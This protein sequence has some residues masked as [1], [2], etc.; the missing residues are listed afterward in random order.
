MS[1]STLGQCWQPMLVQWK[2]SVG[3]TLVLCC[4]A[5]WSYTFRSKMLQIKDTISDAR[6]VVELL[7]YLLWVKTPN[8]KQ[9]CWQRL[10]RHW[11]R[12]IQSWRHIFRIPE[13]VVWWPQSMQR[14][15][16]TLRDIYLSGK[17]HE[18][19]KPINKVYVSLKGSVYDI[20]FW[21]YPYTPMCVALYTQYFPRVLWKKSQAFLLGWDSNPRPLQLLICICLVWLWTIMVIATYLVRSRAACN[22]VMNTYITS[23]PQY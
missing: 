6:V 16:Q 15:K 14:C 3:P 7:L 9:S 5:I 19:Y 1:K 17:K 20:N 13:S 4:D 11:E 2:C 12:R 10:R 22:V 23:Y 8:I 21:F 18:Q